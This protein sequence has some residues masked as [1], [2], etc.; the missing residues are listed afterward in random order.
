MVIALRLRWPR[1]VPLI[2]TQLLDFALRLPGAARR[3]R[4]GDPAWPNAAAGAI[5]MA[6]ASALDLAAD[7]SR[8]SNTLS[9]VAP[10]LRSKSAQKIV[11][12]LLA[13]DCVSPAEA[14]RHA[15]MTG[16]A[17]RRLFDR[18]VALPTKRRPNSANGWERICKASHS[19]DA[20]FHFSDGAFPLGRRANKVRSAKPY[21]TTF[22]IAVRARGRDRSRRWRPCL[23]VSAPKQPS[24]RQWLR[25]RR[26]LDLDR[27]NS[28]DYCSRL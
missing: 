23:R 21:C 13:Q 24:L 20:L 25:A 5:A 17:A 12:L 4:P 10:K 11:D 6:A 2:A 27:F 14:A 22:A 9:A 28:V 26:F 8:R 18:L 15:P 16:R 3:P 1:P 19:L 7:L